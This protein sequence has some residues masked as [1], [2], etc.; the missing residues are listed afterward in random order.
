MDIYGYLW[1]F[2]DISLLLTAMLSKSG[3][4]VEKV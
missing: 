1:I 4:S 3:K 2:M